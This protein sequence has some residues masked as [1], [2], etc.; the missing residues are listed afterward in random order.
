MTR[1]RS[2]VGYAFFSWWIGEKWFVDAYYSRDFE[3]RRDL[4]YRFA[5]N[6]VFHRLAISLE[7]SQD[8]GEDRN[9]TVYFNLAP[10]EMLQSSRHGHRR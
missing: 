4:E 9:S 2:N 3:Q 1:Q 10:V 7:Y 6:R 8:V 5:L